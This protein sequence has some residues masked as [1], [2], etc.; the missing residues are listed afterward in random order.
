MRIDY[1]TVFPDAMQAMRGLE[2]TVRESELEPAAGP[3]RVQR[4]APQIDGGH[5]FREEVPASRSRLELRSRSR[6]I[7]R[8]TSA[9]RPRA[10]GRT[11]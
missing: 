1:R 8:S 2:A 4:S 6:S 11:F 10:T 7:G 9:P 3:L 5:S